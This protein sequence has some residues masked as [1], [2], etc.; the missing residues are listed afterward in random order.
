MK[1]AVG[2]AK[3]KNFMKNLEKLQIF[4][5]GC[6]VLFTLHP[7]RKRVFFRKYWRKPLSN[8]FTALFVADLWACTKPRAFFIPVLRAYVKT[9]ILT[10]SNQR[11]TAEFLAFFNTETVLCADF[12]T[13]S[14]FIRGFLANRVTFLI[15]HYVVRIFNFDALLKWKCVNDS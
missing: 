5:Q 1:R 8:A 7:Y 15:V 9:L 4:A 12:S 11:T 6:F 2:K 10:L 13:F 14:R 3:S